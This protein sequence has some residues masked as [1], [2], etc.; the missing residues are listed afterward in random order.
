VQSHK[1]NW[2]QHSSRSHLSP[3]TPTGRVR[4]NR[5]TWHCAIPLT[6][7]CSLALVYS[8][9]RTAAERTWLRQFIMYLMKRVGYGLRWK[10]YLTTDTK[11]MY[12]HSIRICV[13]VGRDQVYRN[14]GDW[15]SS[16]VVLIWDEERLA[17]VILILLIVY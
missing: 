1:P 7:F 2:Q 4:A 10:N 11:L 8:A 9:Y 5:W 13:C 15:I 14:S 16:P 3:A 17:K 6:L 12:V